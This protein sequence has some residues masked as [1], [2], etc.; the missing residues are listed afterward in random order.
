MG[1]RVDTSATLVL[2]GMD[3]AEVHVT[4]G[5]PLSAL[6]EF[7]ATETREAEWAS[8]LALAAPTWNLE[9]ADGPI[10]VDE[11]ALDR[12]PSNVS[13][14]IVFGWRKALVN[15]PAPLPQPS[16]AGEQ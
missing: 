10:P 9:D 1:Y 16:S 13:R 2:D 7:D 8:F 4:L 3:G 6:R 12:L 11:A 15:P 14:A 5:I